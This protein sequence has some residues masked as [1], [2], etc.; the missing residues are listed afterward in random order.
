M[1]LDDCNLCGTAKATQVM[2][3]DKLGYP[4]NQCVNNKAWVRKDGKW[5]R[6]VPSSLRKAPNPEK[7]T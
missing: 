1:E 5:I 3:R 6:A 4:C 7:S 2:S